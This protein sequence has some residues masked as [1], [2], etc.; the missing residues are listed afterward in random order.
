[1]NLNPSSLPESPRQIYGYR[2]LGGPRSPVSETGQGRPVVEVRVTIDHREDPAFL[3]LAYEA[4]LGFLAPEIAS[5]I[6]RRSQP[7]PHPRQE[8]P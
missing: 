5:G 7:R 4:A 3:T 8:T 1:M 6:A 2:W